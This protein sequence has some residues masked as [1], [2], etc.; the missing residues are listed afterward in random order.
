MVKASQC[1]ISSPTQ[2][3]EEKWECFLLRLQFPELL[4]S[5]LGNK[6]IGQMWKE[7]TEWLVLSNCMSPLPWM[8]NSKPSQM[9]G[10]FIQGL[11]MDPESFWKLHG[12]PQAHDRQSAHF[13]G[14][15]ECKSRFLVT[16]FFFFWFTWHMRSEDSERWENNMD[17]I[18]DQKKVSDL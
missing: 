6:V 5:H 10:S 15:V 1:C 9:P 2:L 3:T 7:P 8:R 12:W 16:F 14:K 18:N 13:S 17:L 11:F 4:S